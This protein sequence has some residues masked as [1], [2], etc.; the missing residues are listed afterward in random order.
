MYGYAISKEVTARSE[1]QFRLGP[2]VLYPILRAME[3][4]GLIVA[5]WEEIKSDRA[6]AKAEGRRR[7][8]YKLTAKGRK[9]LMQRVESHRMW[10]SVID[11]FIG[12]AKQRD[13]QGRVE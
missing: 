1:N 3:A 9:R 7:K 10:R 13:V 12:T 2:G 6:Q 4:D 8:W 5:E 11:L